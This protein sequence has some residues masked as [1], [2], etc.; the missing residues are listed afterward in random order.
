MSKKLRQR[1]IFSSLIVIVLGLIGFIFAPDYLK[2]ALI[3]TTVDIDDYKI[4]ENRTIKTD[5]IHHIWRKDSSYNQYNLTTVQREQLEDNKSIAYLVVKDANILYEEYWDGY[6][7]QSYSNSFSMAKSIISLL[8]GIAI[9][10][11]KIASLDQCVGDF[12]MEYKDSANAKLTI[13][14]LLTMSSGLDWDESYGSPFSITTKAYYG[15]DLLSLVSNLK[16]VDEPG[17]VFKYLSGNTQLLALVLER[18]T[19]RTVSDYA[20]TRLWKRIGAKH[21]A[22]WSL[23]KIHGREKAYCCFN[24]NIRDFARI[25]QLVLNEGRWNGKQIVPHQFIIE[26]VQPSGVM[27]NKDGD[28]VD[29]YGYHWWIMDYKGMRIPY[30]RGILGQYIFVLFDYNTVVVRLGHER[31]KTHIDN[32]PIDAYHYIETAISIIEN[33]KK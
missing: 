26:A 33:N 21:P 17:K 3:Y 2:R 13:R 19:G 29:Y 28:L 16:V 11:E 5:T 32:T 30:A 20:S 25:G 31:S 24:S 1:I 18:A 14:N 22:L 8:I 9:G 27:V 4:F 15:K 12:V 6:T 23:D 7:E 10:E